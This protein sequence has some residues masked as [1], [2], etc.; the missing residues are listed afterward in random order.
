M[1]LKLIKNLLSMQ[2]YFRIQ[3]VHRASRYYGNVG[4]CSAPSSFGTARKII[5]ILP[6]LSILSVGALRLANPSDLFA[7]IS[8]LEVV[9]QIKNI[10]SLINKTNSFKPLHIGKDSICAGIF[11]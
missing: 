5:E 9:F 1:Q 4:R 8:I 6:F 2:L 3:I 11:P 10:I 7:S